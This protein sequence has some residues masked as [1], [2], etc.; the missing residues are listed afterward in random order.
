MEIFIGH[1]IIPYGIPMYL[2]TDNGPQ[3]VGKCFTTLCET[4]GAKQ[5]TNTTYHPQINSQK[6][7][8]NKTIVSQIRH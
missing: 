6:E 7:R 5:F 4:L 3:F 2:R 8:Y 1:C